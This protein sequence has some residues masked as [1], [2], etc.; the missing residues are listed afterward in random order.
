[1]CRARKPIQRIHLRDPVVPQRPAEPLD[2]HMHAHGDYTTALTCSAF[3]AQAATCFGNSANLPCV[4]RTEGLL[5]FLFQHGLSTHVFPELSGG[6][7]GTVFLF[8]R[9]TLGTQLLGAGG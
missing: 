7:P 6:F 2:L 3:S 8:L 5:G 9:G 1:M 4:V